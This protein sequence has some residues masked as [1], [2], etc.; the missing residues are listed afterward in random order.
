[1]SD[2]FR[3][4]REHNIDIVEFQWRKKLEN[5]L[6]LELYNE[7]ISMAGHNEILEINYIPSQ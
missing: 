5:Q 6:D 7:I 1:M 4:L 2:F 3:I